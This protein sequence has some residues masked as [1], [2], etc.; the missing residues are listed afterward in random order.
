MILDDLGES[1]WRLWGSPGRPRGDQEAPR[2]PADDTP[3]AYRGAL[4]DQKMARATG[5]G[6]W[7]KKKYFQIF[8]QGLDSQ[9]Y[10]KRNQK[11]SRQ[12]KNLVEA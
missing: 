5:A 12:K 9:M 2:W 6:L 3:E 11:Y 4:G 7:K 10:Q 8:H 1:F